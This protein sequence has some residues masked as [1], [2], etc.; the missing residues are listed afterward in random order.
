MLKAVSPSHRVP[1]GPAMLGPGGTD[2]PH[3][4][5]EL[6]CL[7]NSME[8]HIGWNDLYFSMG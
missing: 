6:D 5:K 8:Q 7:W 2:A 4:R 1:P 3:Y